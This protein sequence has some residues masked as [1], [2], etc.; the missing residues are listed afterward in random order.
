ARR[1]S[2]YL[3][4]LRRIQAHGITVNGCFILGLDRHTPDVFPEILDF[5]RRVPLYDVQITILTPFPGTPLYDRLLREGRILQPERWDLCTLCDV[6]Y[7]PKNMTPQQLRE[8]ILWLTERLYRK[9]CL[10]ERRQPFFENLWR[11]THSRPA[12]TPLRGS[13]HSARVHLPQ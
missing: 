4:A 6:N 10:A 13:E 7:A 12:I 9:E 2:S 11:Q 8:G 1:A 3:D 5:A